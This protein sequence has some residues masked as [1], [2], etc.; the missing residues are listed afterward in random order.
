MRAC[1]EY[2]RAGAQGHAP[3][4]LYSPS[5]PCLNAVPVSNGIGTLNEGPLHQALKSLYRDA[6]AQ[7]EVAVGSYVADVMCEATDGDK[8]LY[9][10]QTS[11]FSGLRR[12]LEHLLEEYRVVLVHP[13]AARR[14]IVKQPLAADADQP[15]KRRRSP[16]KGRLANLLDALVSIPDLLNH[17]RFELEIV[18]TSEEEL[19]VPSTS[20]SWRRKGWRVA[21]RDLLEVLERER[22]SSLDDLWRLAPGELPQVFTTQELADA[23]DEPR[24]LAQKLAYCLREGGAIEIVGK[25]GN[26]LEYRRARRDR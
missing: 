11:G 5:A 1:S 23:M 19:R 8:V 9:E 7:E 20:R 24:W 4:V 10:I 25:S 18:L 14:Y 26:A 16:K 12:K 21:R 17:P 22:F 15:P 3:A 2:A 13:I 6:D